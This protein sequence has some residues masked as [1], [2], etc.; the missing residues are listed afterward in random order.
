MLEYDEIVVFA[1]DETGKETK[2][3]P[4]QWSCDVE[5]GRHMLL[6]LEPQSAQPPRAP[7]HP[8]RPAG[9]RERPV[10]AGHRYR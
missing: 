1:V 6:R 7:P 3:G 2:H 9:R 8:R 10:R 4:A 5:V